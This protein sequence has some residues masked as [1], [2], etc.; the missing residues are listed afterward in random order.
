MARGSPTSRRGN[1]ISSPKHSHRNTQKIVGPHSWAL[2]SP[3]KLEL[4]INHHR[5]YVKSGPREGALCLVYLKHLGEQNQRQDEWGML[6]SVSWD[7]SERAIMPPTSHLYACWK[8][9]SP[10]IMKDWFV[11]WRK[12]IDYLFLWSESSRTRQKW[13]EREGREQ[14]GSLVSLLMGIT[15]SLLVYCAMLLL[16]Q[17]HWA[18]PRYHSDHPWGTPGYEDEGWF[19]WGATQLELCK[20]L[21]PTR[22]CP[23]VKP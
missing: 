3:V 23:G 5:G 21:P 4:R 17:I 14:G 18:M 9:Q 13:V 7:V 11:L 2:G 19:S 20:G 1:L 22:C 15:A 8:C 6:F 10:S 16:L 12:F